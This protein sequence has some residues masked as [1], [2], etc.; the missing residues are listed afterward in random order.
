MVVFIEVSDD[1]EE[2]DLGSDGMGHDLIIGLDPGTVKEG[3]DVYQPKTG[4]HRMVRVDLKLD[5]DPETGRFNQYDTNEDHCYILADRLTEGYR[6]Q[7]ERANVIAIEKQMALEHDR[8]DMLLFGVALVAMCMGKFPHAHV[9]V[10]R[11]QKLRGWAG[12][13]GHDY[14]HRKKLSLA[15]LRGILRPAD[16]E[17]HVHVFGINTRTA[18]GNDAGEALLLTLYAEHNYDELVR[19]S[20]EKPPFK[21][22]EPTN[23]TVARQVWLRQGTLFNAR[24]AEAEARGFSCPAAAAARLPTLQPRKRKAAP[25]KRKKRFRR[26]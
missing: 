11:P 5:W 25:K 18:E 19:Q 8:R 12:T 15:F 21:T 17:R 2:E 3:I 16:F 6:D 9:F 7:L 1:E 20:Q 10:V 23:T 4:V 13:S 22:S 14:V 26:G 24:Y